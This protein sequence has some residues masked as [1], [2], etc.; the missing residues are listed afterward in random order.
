MRL[1]SRGTIVE[2]AVGNAATRTVPVRRPDK[3]GELARGGLERRGDAD[4]VAREHRA[5]L[6]Q[7]HAATRPG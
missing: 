7:A 2:D 3:F 4:R 6:G 1:S 5:R